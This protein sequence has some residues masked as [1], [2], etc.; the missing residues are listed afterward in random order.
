MGA[1]SQG[2]KLVTGSRSLAVASISS[3]PR[4]FTL[5]CFPTPSLQLLRYFLNSIGDS[6]RRISI[7]EWHL[8]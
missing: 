2:M 3:K 1:K 8:C 4:P 6:H 5:N 7:D